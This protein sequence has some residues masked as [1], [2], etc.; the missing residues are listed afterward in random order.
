MSLVLRHWPGT[1][2]I[3]DVLERL[4]G[5][6]GSDGRQIRGDP[7]STSSSLRLVLSLPYEQKGPLA[8]RLPGA[9]PTEELFC[10][11]ISGAR[12]VV[13]VFSPYVDPTFTALASDT[14]VPIRIVTTIREGRIKSNPVLERCATVRPISVRYLH[15]KKGGSQMF[16]L[17]AKMILSDRSAAYV[18]SA[19]FTDT[20]LRYNLELGLYVEDRAVIADL[21]RLFDYLFDFVAV[22]AQGGN[23]P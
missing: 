7:E 8:E 14:K 3:P 11:L 13:K 12:E 16:Q 18:G 5:W 1:C 22:P 15:E 10:K 19:N 21:H 6:L 9:I 17:H 20:S 4:R 23:R 2:S